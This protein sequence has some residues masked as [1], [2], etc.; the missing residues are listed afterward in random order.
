MLFGLYLVED[1]F[2]LSLFINQKSHAVIAHVLS[3]Q[4][5]LLTIG[6]IGFRNRLVGIRQKTEGQVVLGREFSVGSFAIERYSQ[7]LNAAPLEFSK[8]IAK[9]TCF[10]G[11]TRRVVF[12]IEI[13]HDLLAAKIL[14][15]DR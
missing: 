14:Q 15:F 2:D 3:A 10:P 8:C 12:G 7:D 13:E 9:L 6:T 11:A 1:L 5:L 4:K